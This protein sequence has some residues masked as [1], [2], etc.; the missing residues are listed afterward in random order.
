MG[1]KHFL[2]IILFVAL[3]L[4]CGRTTNEFSITGHIEGVDD[5]DVVE[6][7]KV[8]G[9]VGKRFLQ[10]TLRDGKFTFK[11]ESDSLEQI[12]L[13]VMGAQYP[14]KSIPIWIAPR[15]KTKITGRGYYP[16][17]WRVRSNVKEQKDEEIYR[18]ASRVISGISD[19]LRW[20]YYKEGDK[21]AQAVSDEERLKQRGIARSIRQ[22]LDSVTFIENRIIFD[23]MVNHP[24]TDQWINRLKMY[25]SNVAA[26]TSMGVT[27]PE[28]NIQKM[29]E[30]YSRLNEEQKHSKD[31]ELIYSYIF[32]IKIMGIGDPMA[33][34]NFFDPEGKEHRITDY[35]NKG[36]YILLDFWGVGCVP[37]IAA[38]PE[39]KQLHESHSDKLTI[40]GISTDSHA[41]WMEGMEKHPLP[42][43]N[44]NDFLGLEGYANF[45]GVRAIPFYVLISPDGII[46]KIWMGYAK[47][48]F[49]DVV[50]NIHN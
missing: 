2:F 31:G 18:E 46:E 22:H 7:F 9:R 43:L 20:L 40:I 13:M 49:E 41:I 23:E 10:D 27:Y 37:C 11:G 17:L 42:W 16:A 12:N 50:K 48:M 39:M 33:E 35:K 8:E 14:L 19:S 3:I 34:G 44:L 47:G 6:L 5:G 26:Y 4:A 1:T 15:S 25:S 36:K 21:I 32:P 28:E 45:Y 24:V 29:Q 38:F 30:L